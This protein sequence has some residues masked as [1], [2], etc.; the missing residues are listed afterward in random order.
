[1]TAPHGIRRNDRTHSGERGIAALFF[2]I[3]VTAMLAVGALVLGGSIGYTADR[4]AQ[5]AA[6]TAALA[7]ATTLRDHKQDWVTTPASD[8]LD[9]VRSVVEHNGG[10]LAPDGCEVVDAAYALT[11]DDADVIAECADLEFLS[12][13]DFAATAGVRVTVLDTRDVPFSAFIDHQDTITGT[14]V[15]TATI[16]PVVEGRAPFMVCTSPD[17]VGHPTQALVS[18]ADDPTGYSVNPAAIGKLYVLWG[19]QVKYQGRDCGKPSSDWRGLVEFETSFPVPSPDASDDTYWWRTESGN[20]NGTLPVT[21]AGD[22][23]CH[24][25][26]EGVSALDLGCRIAVPL[27]PMGNGSTVDF[28]LYCVKIGVFEI[29]N[30]GSRVQQRHHPTGV[31]HAV[32]DGEEQHHLREVPRCR[33]RHRRPWRGR[34]ARSELGRGR[35]ARRVSPIDSRWQPRAAATDRPGVPASRPAPNRS[36]YQAP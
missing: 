6:D 11:K 28:R 14:A 21:L 25:D 35:Q 33:Q 24:L 3:S 34:D 29:S 23:A 27:C 19:N 8:V 26:G 32:W 18:N 4:N 9:T 20:K 31:R 12:K 30:I 2:A 16:Q 10:K 36:M 13:E 1:M 22:D 15:A 17:A 5:T 7:G